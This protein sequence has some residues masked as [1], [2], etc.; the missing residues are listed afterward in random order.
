MV[1]PNV[2]PS[3]KTDWIDGQG[4]KQTGQATI[5][6]DGLKAE[7]AALRAERDRLRGQNAAIRAECAER[8]VQWL[9][10]QTGNIDPAIAA[11]NSGKWLIK[12][13]EK[14]AVQLC[15]AVRGEVE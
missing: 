5:D 10:E 2:F 4:F 1:E 13:R 3:A 8:A 15:A 11:T 12:L 7:L 6:I 9:A 14:Q